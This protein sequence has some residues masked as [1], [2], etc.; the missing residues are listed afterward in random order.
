MTTIDSELLRRRNAVRSASKTWETALLD[1]TGRNPLRNFQDRRTGSLDLTPTAENE[2]NAA[3]LG[4][5]LCGKEIRTT[6]LF[7]NLDIRKDAMRRLATISRAAQSNLDEKGID[8]LF[9]VAGLATWDLGEGSDP[10]A[11]VLLLPIRIA[12]T[13]AARSG[14][15]MSVSGDI[16]GNPLLIHLLQNE[17]GLDISDDIESISDDMP[18]DFESLMERL[19]AYGR[20]WAESVSG[21]AIDERMVI[22]NFKYVNMAMVDDLSKNA[23][24]FA[25]NDIV[26]AIAGVPEAKARLGSRIS[27]ASLD[28]PDRIP[29]QAEYLILDADASQHRAINRALD[30]ESI[31]VWG[32]PGTG[33]SQVI[34]NL[35]G[36]F[37]AYGKRVLFVAEKRAA[38]DVVMERLDEAGLGDLVMD[39]HGGIGS[40][41]DFAQKLDVS[42]RGIRKI[43]ERDYT[44]LHL[45][46]ERNRGRLID[47]M[48]KVHDIREPWGL[49]VFDIQS[50]L[51]DTE[52]ADLKGRR[53][54][55]D[56]ARVI[57]A[58]G[59]AKLQESLRDWL[60]LEGH[61]Y[62]VDY[63]LW[64]RSKIE[65]RD[66][67]RI[68]FEIA[69]DIDDR[70]GAI[71]GDL[72]EALGDVGLAAPDTVAEWMRLLDWLSEIERMLMSFSEDIYAI[73]H[74]E[75]I[76]ALEL[77][78]KWH[79][80][81]T[82][83][84]SRR[85]RSALETVRA[86]SA[87]GKQI[88]SRDAIEVLERAQAHVREWRT[89][90][91]GDSAPRAPAGLRGLRE[92]VGELTGMF[93]RLSAYLPA[94]DSMKMPYDQL[95]QTVAALVAQRQAAFN[96]PDVLQ[97][98]EDFERAGVIEFVR[99]AG[100]ELPVENLGNAVER[101]WL[102]AAWND[103]LFE[104]PGLNN[105]SSVSHNRRREEFAELDRDHIAASPDRI[106]RKVAEFAI[107]K[108]N[109]FGDEHEIISR[110]AV[111]KRRLLPVRELLRR[112][113]NVITAI[114]PCWAMSPLLV[115]ELI[116]ADRK[117]FDVVI[118]DEASQI[119]PEEA[120]C[121]LA[122]APQAIIAG[123]HL[124]LPPTDFFSGV[125]AAEGDEEEE[126]DFTLFT[127]GAESI[128]DVARA[129]IVRDSL[130]EWHYRS[131]DSRLIAFSNAHI[132]EGNLTAFPGPIFAS[133]FTHHLV[134]HNPLIPLKGNTSHPDEVAAV[135]DLAIEHARNHPD[136]TLGVIAFGIR[137]ANN[138][139]EAL[140][141]RLR[142]E[143]N[144]A[145]DKFFST[146]TRE[147][148]FVKNLETVQGDERDVIILS[149][150][151]HKD[152]DGRLLYRF[153][154]LNQEGGERRLNVAVTRARSRIHL[155]SSFSHQ[156]MDP[157][158]SSAKGV[159]L[160][161]RYLQFAAS[162]G[163]DLG[164][165][166]SDTP[167]NPFEMD[168]QRRLEREG[169]PVTPQ[170][171]SVGYRLDF[172][173]SHPRRPG[174]MVL[175]IEADGAMYHSGHTARERDRLRQQVLE[176]KGWRFHRI[177]ST[178][179]FKAPDG[180]TKK[181][182]AAWNRAVEDSDAARSR[183]M[184][185]EE[186]DEDERIVVDDRDGGGHAPVR[187][188]RPPVVAGQRI[189]KYKAY[190]LVELAE[191]ILSDTLLR[192][193]DELMLE[194]RNEL[195]FKRGGKRID[196]ALMSAIRMVRDRT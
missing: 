18:E 136:E 119:P 156:D 4:S 91:G 167:L 190:Q 87:A 150:G 85:Y 63:A 68:A 129:G 161:R 62:P 78:G 116:P 27:E 43:P 151:Y 134:P 95:S 192:T 137:H 122:R 23:E 145:L 112:A 92:R 14:Y 109:E 103:L 181:A 54:W 146:M 41:R 159:E 34:A 120:I 55:R 75:A 66:D 22:A 36:N 21:F 176:D 11:P 143:G 42:L 61:R 25:E 49:R 51:I 182:V 82:V 31:V 160:L 76:A 117:M 185:A 196:A 2:I 166:V 35:I 26:A 158:C 135:V 140:R 74:Q 13:D 142:N 12:S 124:Q 147:R 177:W 83:L 165:F 101:A 24:L 152:A 20:K 168:I 131:R 99:A 60:D 148:F 189:E 118:F 132:Y 52:G 170:Y 186:N 10:N 6:A 30:G 84:F 59:M 169:V 113:P 153:G 15:K 90:T 96:L 144:G 47:H 17:C 94:F 7:P 81:V 1:L 38:I 71:H 154:P 93:L 69:R 105:F 138:I 9:A 195:G 80:I 5:L 126:L 111:K 193:D 46:V 173:C 40:K 149:V 172:A 133:P 188:V 194:M 175:A 73:D 64:H 162:G 125:P 28:M 104:D 139:E 58:N 8:T 56:K 98:E 65:L 19:R 33:K 16:H 130:L 45:N 164:T 37:M 128:L 72:Q 171:G 121:S 179:W 174:D 89:L 108:M 110:E 191:W 86:A 57:D 67:A 44:H 79:S 102:Q 77:G 184:E 53:M 107:Q 123:D 114:R 88:W 100:N 115:A 32:P 106:K 29:P 3:S 187:A 70:L 48:K 97:L 180:E 50:R 141:M 155:V 157:G 127:E 178:D 163:S 183:R 39:A